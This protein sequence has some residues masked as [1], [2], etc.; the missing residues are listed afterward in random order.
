MFTSMRRF[1][2]ISVLNFLLLLSNET[3]WVLNVS[4]DTDSIHNTKQVLKRH[5]KL[6]INNKRR[7]FTTRMLR[8]RS[9]KNV[10]IFKYEPSIK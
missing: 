7:L 10:C 4:K 5:F 3:D 2:F 8:N 1:W 6:H 9:V